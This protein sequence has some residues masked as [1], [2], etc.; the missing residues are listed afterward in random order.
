MA[1]NRHSVLDGV[2]A[3]IKREP[4]V[5]PRADPLAQPIDATTNRML[6]G[7][8]APRTHGRRVPDK[9]RRVSYDLPKELVPLVKW[10]AL[11]AGVSE[12]QAATWLIAAGLNATTLSSLQSATTPSRIPIRYINSIPEFDWEVLAEAAEINFA[13]A[14]SKF[15]D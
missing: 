8:R 4:T 15:G 5:E 2:P 9:K 3:P 1:P 6:N 11:K 7:R 14:M 12:S 10:M 13:E